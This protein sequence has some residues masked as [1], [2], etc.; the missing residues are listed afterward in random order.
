VSTRGFLSAPTGTLYSASLLT[1]TVASEPSLIKLEQFS[2]LLE[3]DLTTFK[4]TETQKDISP[5]CIVF[6][7]RTGM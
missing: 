7:C 2:G 1:H 5:S 4:A 3:R 6:A